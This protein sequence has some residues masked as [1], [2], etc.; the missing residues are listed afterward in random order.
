MKTFFWRS[1]K[2]YKI[3]ASKKVLHVYFL[4][5]KVKF[6]RISTVSLFHHTMNENKDIETPVPEFSEILPGFSTNL[7]FWEYACKP[8]S[9]TTVFKAAAACLLQCVHH[10]GGSNYYA[11]AT[12]RHMRHLPR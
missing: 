5:K 4:R 12:L 3:T 6:R 7:S 8:A 11:V 1:H 2:T 9:Y 10:R